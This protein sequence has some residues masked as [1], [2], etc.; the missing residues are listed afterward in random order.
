MR[1]DTV[2]YDLDNTLL[3]FN[4]SQ[5]KAFFRAFP[6][7]GE[8][9]YQAFET[10]NRA[11]WKRLERGEATRE[12]ILTRRF[13]DFFSSVGH[14]EDP[15]KA[16]RRY[17]EELGKGCEVMPGIPETLEALKNMGCA[18]AVVTNGLASVQRPRLEA[19]GLL[20]FFR[21]VLVSEETGF[22]KP[23]PRI[24]LEAAR[25]CGAKD[26]GRVLV[27]GDT[28]SSDLAGGAA[29]GFDTCWY[30]FEDQPLPAGVSPAY[31]ITRPQEILPIVRGEAL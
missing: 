21:C 16:N 8:A 24:F 27:I 12:E 20:P 3:D 2:L 17:V 28:P 13:S 15:A 9:F 7:K 14:S 31:V 19:S 22:V 29:A 11:Q 26:P 1:Y 10:V 4:N 6:G 5:K 25:R 18:L 30:R 23:D